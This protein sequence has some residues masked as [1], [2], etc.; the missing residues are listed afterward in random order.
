MNELDF[1]QQLKLLA[2]M[3]EPLPK[4]KEEYR[5]YYDK[6]SGDPLFFSMES[7]AG[8]YIIVTKEDYEQA[9]INYIQVVNGKL[10]R[11]KLQSEIQNRFV[12]SID[13]IRTTENEIQFVVDE[14]YTG[15]VSIWKLD[16]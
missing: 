8:D 6:S 9:A 3:L 12:P 4:F 7:P 2:T 15:P 16:D 5:L 11:K 14:T 13:G 10:V 1:Q